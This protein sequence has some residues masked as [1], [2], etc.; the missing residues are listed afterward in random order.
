[1]TRRAGASRGS[2]DPYGLAAVGGFVGPVVALVALVAVGA[3][4]VGLMNGQVPFRGGNAG[5]GNPVGPN[6]TPAPTNVVIVEPEVTF[7]G[8]IVYAKAG[9]IWVQTGN[10]PRQLTSSGLDS[11]PTF[12]PDGEWVYY[13]HQVLGKGRHQVNGH[14][15]WFDLSTPE[16]D[17]VKT[18]GTGEPERIVSGRIK[19]GKAISYYW[20]REP[21]V[22]PDG[23]RIALVSDGPDPNKSQVVLQIYDMTTKKFTKAKLAQSEFG[24]QDPAWDPNGGYILFVKNGRDGARGAPL[25]QK[26]NPANNRSFTITGP[27]YLSPSWSPDGKY[28]AATRTDSFGTDV[29]VLDATTGVELLRVTDDDA[30]FSP[31][32]SPAGDAIAFLHLEGMI[33]D[34]KLAKLVGSSGSW[35]VGETTSLTEVSG[36][37]AASR[38]GWF[39]P[40]SELPAPSPS[41]GPSGSASGSGPSPSA[42]P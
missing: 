2:R 16:I 9:N 34:L 41:A 20:I 35:T 21:A 39:V 4:T 30:S 12:S 22:A 14:L 3:M 40:A 13:V 33:V 42:S 10:E 1:M 23:N 26:F 29:V 27:G 15:S 5:P 6:R 38:P 8:S 28:F 24:H 31:A 11:M 19:S 7:P 32:W 36:L 37:D 25:I 18:D 17:R